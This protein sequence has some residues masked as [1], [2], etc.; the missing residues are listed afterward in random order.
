[1]KY[2]A[3]I[4][5]LFGTL[6]DV[7]SKAEYRA[8][9]DRLAPVLGVPGDAFHEAWVEAWP[10]RYGGDLPTIEACIEHACRA[11]GREPDPA[12]VREATRLRI[13]GVRRWLAPRDGAVEV[14]RRARQAGLKTGLI[15]DCD[16][17]IARVWPESQLAPLID[18]AVFS[19]IER[20]RKP[21]PRI[22]RRACRR[23]AVR[24]ERCLYVGDG[25]SRELSGAARVGMEA[26]LIR[27]PY[28]DCDTV[29]RVEEEAWSGRRISSLREGLEL[30]G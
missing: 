26:V 28:E 27:V 17:G 16:A 3:V 2:E 13:E 23:L 8:W 18:A 30:I 11:C 5:D 9:H 15:S 1:M 10:A 7:A 24:P 12:A 22:Y 25:G 20:V 21:D 14:L 29:H 4:F 19:C 6:V